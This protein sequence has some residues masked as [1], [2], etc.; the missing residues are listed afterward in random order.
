MWGCVFAGLRPW[1]R[2][3]ALVIQVSSPAN[4]RVRFGYETFSLRANSRCG[5]MQESAHNLATQEMF[6]TASVGD[7]Y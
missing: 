7:N 5:L 3:F 4:R 2:L 6:W 1:P